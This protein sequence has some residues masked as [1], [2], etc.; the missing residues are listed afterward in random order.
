[1]PRVFSV[2]S[3]LGQRL[4][5]YH[6][7]LCSWPVEALEFLI[8]TPVP[9]PPLPSALDRLQ[10]AN[11]LADELE[12]YRRLRNAYEIELDQWVEANGQAVSKVIV[13][14]LHSLEK[15]RQ[16]SCAMSSP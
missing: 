11:L 4:S 6:L 9:L 8:A 12:E 7:F 15:V 14:T 10:P 1:M 2:P 3:A 16:Y 13:D 5:A